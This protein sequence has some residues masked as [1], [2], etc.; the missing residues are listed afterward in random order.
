MHLKTITFCFSL[1][2]VTVGCSSNKAPMGEGGIAEHNYSNTPNH[3]VG[4]ENALYFELQLSQR[5]LDALLLDGAKICFPA[6]VEK[7]EIREA[8]IARQLQGGL[9]GD[10]A[11]DLIIQR[12]QLDRMERR[13]NYVQLQDSCLP[14]ESYRGNEPGH[15]A[16]N[17]L[18]AETNE[19]LST[20]THD[21]IAHLN[22]LLN[23]NNQFVINSTALNPRYI[24]Q[25]SEAAQILKLHPQYHLKLTGHAD[26]TGSQEA[27]LTLSLARAAQVER[28]LLIFGFNPN[29]IEIEAKGSTQPLFDE[30]NPQ[31][32]LVNRRVNIELINI[33]DAAMAMPQ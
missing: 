25:L 22:M 16:N 23:N 28:Y 18:S 9:P 33:N 24:A 26:A 11:N 30:N 2:F 15:M 3:P 10:A 14:T 27:N 21:E 19:Q 7:A 32:R 13:L 29:N 1:L 17:P 5:H 8:R 6:S 12:D 31:V 20:L 4:L